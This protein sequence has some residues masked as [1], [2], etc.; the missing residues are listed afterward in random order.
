MSLSRTGRLFNLR[1]WEGQPTLLHLYGKFPDLL[2][3]ISGKQ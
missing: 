3:E 1:Y 2:G